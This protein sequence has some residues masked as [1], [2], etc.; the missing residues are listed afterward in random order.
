MGVCRQIVESLP[1]PPVRACSLHDFRFLGSPSK[2]LTPLPT[3]IIYPPS[4]LI[5]P[6]HMSSMAHL[7]RLCR[8]LLRPRTM[9]IMR[10]HIRI[11]STRIPRRMRTHITST[12]CIRRVHTTTTVWATTHHHQP[13]P[14]RPTRRLAQP[15]AHTPSPRVPV[16]SAP[17]QKCKC[18]RSPSADLSHPLRA[19]AARLPY[20][21]QV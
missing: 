10:T 9:V 3:H 18:T 2:A 15:P 7:S 20:L 5:R 19:W 16:R 8:H 13:R 17:L 21:G 6:H 14:R 12:R 1:R 11:H 4:L